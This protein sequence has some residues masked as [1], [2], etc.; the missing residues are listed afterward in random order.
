MRASPR[1][2]VYNEDA[3][4]PIEFLTKWV[5]DE[6][7]SLPKPDDIEVVPEDP[8]DNLRVCP[9]WFGNAIG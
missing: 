4:K 1:T 3:N 8:E 2:Q 6:C 9:R 5:C 7:L